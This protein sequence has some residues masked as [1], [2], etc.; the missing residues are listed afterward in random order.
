MGVRGVR[1]GGG[2]WISGRLPSWRISGGLVHMRLHGQQLCR[3]V[4]C[5][6]K[7]AKE[8]RTGQRIS[9]RRHG[10]HSCRMMQNLAAD[11]A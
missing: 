3:R 6:R 9:K 11:G 2:G 10:T 1:G 5:S 8:R 4:P 7:E